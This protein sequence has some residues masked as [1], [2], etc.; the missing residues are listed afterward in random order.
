MPLKY[1]LLA[2][3]SVIG[4]WLLAVYVYIGLGVV[5]AVALMF[6]LCHLR[7]DDQAE[8]L[9][10]AKKPEQRLGDEVYSAFAQTGTLIKDSVNN[11]SQDMEA[12]IGIQTDAIATLTRAFTG[13]K[14]LLEVQQNEIRK[15]L[16]DAG[17][18]QSSAQSIGSRM[19]IF[20]R[21]TSETLNRFVDT[22]VTMSAA[23]MGLVEKVGAIANQMPNV[24]KALQDID[25]IAAQTNLLA[26]NAAIEAA[27][28]GEAGRGFAVVADEVRALSTRSAGFSHEI[29][30]Q[31]SSI[32]SAIHSLTDEVGSV[33]SQDMTYVLDARREVEQAIEELI[34]RAEND[35]QVANKLNEVATRLV[36]ALHQAMRG[37]QFEDMSRQNISHCVGLLHSLQP[38]AQILTKGAGQSLDAITA[39]LGKEVQLHRTS[40]IHNSANPVSATSMK[41]GDIDLF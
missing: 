41:S 37:L 34:D 20:A 30:T 21:N 8:Q 26:L 10:Q 11:A 6:Y 38:I 36:D 40:A 35:Q 1:L 24:M 4:G 7:L 33:A 9:R 5:F 2:L 32:N 39:A 12:L 18:N 31:L 13:L 22:T 14:E 19:S 27:R 23:S 25:Q 16:F 28:A 3:A 17:D 29:Q 15:L